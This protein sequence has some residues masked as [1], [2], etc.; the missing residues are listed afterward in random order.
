MKVLNIF[1]NIACM[2]PVKIKI[3]YTIFKNKLTKTNLEEEK[4]L[5]ANNCVG[6]FLFVYT[7]STP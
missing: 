2:M 4:T 1:P 5:N 3:K 7:M 6:F